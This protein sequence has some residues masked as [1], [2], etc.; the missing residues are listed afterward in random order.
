VHAQIGFLTLITPG[1]GQKSLPLFW[2]TGT[3]IPHDPFI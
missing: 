2:V 1:L 3:E